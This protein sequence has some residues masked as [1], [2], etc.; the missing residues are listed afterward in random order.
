MR[1]AR[2]LQVMFTCSRLW[3][4]GWIAW[5]LASVS[6]QL[7]C[8]FCFVFSFTIEKYQ[9]HAKWQDTK[10][11]KNGETAKTGFD[12]KE[13][14]VA[15]LSFCFCFEGCCMEIGLCT[16]CLRTVKDWFWLVLVSFWF[17]SFRTFVFEKKN[18]KR[19]FYTN[20]TDWYGLVPLSLLIQ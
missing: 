11:R 13:G 1:L 20:T 12:W 2:I 19:K 15:L 5:R 14:F 6:E 16:P 3:K 10:H 7:D 18:K 9:M 4:S 17:I 8:V